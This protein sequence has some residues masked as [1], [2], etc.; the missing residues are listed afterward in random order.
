MLSGVVENVNV[1]P[2]LDVVNA[3]ALTVE[4]TEKSLATPVVAL[5][6]SETLM[7]HTTGRPVREGL[8]LEQERL[9]KVVGLP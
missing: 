6:S 9:D 8:V 3:V 5:T 7:V 4:T 2:P 1:D